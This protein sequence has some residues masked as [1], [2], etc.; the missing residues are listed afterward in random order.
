MILGGLRVGELTALRWA[1]VD[2][3]GGKVRVLAA[4][5]E[6]GQ[7]VVDVSP[8]L[9][10][11]LKRHRADSRHAGPEDLVFCTS[12]GTTLNRNNIRTRVVGK[13][14][15]RA[16]VALA[17]AETPTIQ[18]RVTNHSLRRTFASLLYEAGASPAYVMSQ[19]GHT[20]SALALEVYAKK[21][22]R[23]RD[24][25]ARMDALIQGADW[26]QRAQTAPPLAKPFAE[27]ATE[28]A[29]NPLG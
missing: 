23:S 3:A 4:K 15:E 5:T 10:D 22:A 21:M 29:A 9:L 13:A 25:G 6:A 28:E 14:V 2:L 17:K 24:T 26:A 12:K 19:M 11:E 16:N 7:R 20:S 27:E 18:G 8:M 1:Q